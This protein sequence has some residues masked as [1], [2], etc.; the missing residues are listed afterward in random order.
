ME[1]NQL[2]L[3]PKMEEANQ[4]ISK[5]IQEKKVSPTYQEIADHLGVK[6]RSRIAY[7]VDEL[8][9][10]TNLRKKT[11]VKRALYYEHR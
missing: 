11:G 9:K 1:T 7:L 4:Y 8:M 10:R 5:Y 2:S 6:T 3:S